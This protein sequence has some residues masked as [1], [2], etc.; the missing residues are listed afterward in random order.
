MKHQAVVVN[1]PGSGES[2]FEKGSGSFLFG[3]KPLKKR[4]NQ[5]CAVN[6]GLLLESYCKNNLE[7]IC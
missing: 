4:I 3:L 5:K 6:S 7:K 1:L 2:E